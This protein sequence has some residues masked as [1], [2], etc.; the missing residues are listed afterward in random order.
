MLSC[1]LNITSNNELLFPFE[2]GL[3]MSD[4]FSNRQAFCVLEKFRIA[5][6]TCSLLNLKKHQS[7]ELSVQDQIFSYKLFLGTDAFYSHGFDFNKRVG[8]EGKLNQKASAFNEAELYALLEQE[9]RE[10]DLNVFKSP[11]AYFIFDCTDEKNLTSKGYQ[12]LLTKVD[13]AL[14]E[15][16][17]SKVEDGN[18]VALYATLPDYFSRGILFQILQDEFGL[19]YN[20]L[21][22]FNCCY[23]LKDLMLSNY[24]KLSDSLN[25]NTYKL[26][27][28]SKVLQASNVAY[29]NK[30]SFFNC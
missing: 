9:H 27:A 2:Q 30:C 1:E 5:D 3:K 4:T 23:S 26:K 20:F 25:D 19:D 28:D 10:F 29:V 11:Y 13:L 7:F 22:K 12:N 6:H 21:R 17:C 15:L 16:Y 18:K 8:L 24:N 14:N